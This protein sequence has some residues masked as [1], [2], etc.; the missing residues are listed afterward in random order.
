MN[1]ALF[2]LLYRSWEFVQVCFCPGEWWEHKP[3][4]VPRSCMWDWSKGRKKRSLCCG[5]S[6]EGL[7]GYLFLS[8]QHNPR[9]S[10]W[11]YLEASRSRIL[12]QHFASYS[13]RLTLEYSWLCVPYP[14]R[15]PYSSVQYN[16]H[17]LDLATGPKVISFKLEVYWLFKSL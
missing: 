4:V 13:F 12:T 10:P 17:W 5:F 8:G 9:T 11:V 16:K 2:V 15:H 1:L 14:W 3:P 7:H 6:V